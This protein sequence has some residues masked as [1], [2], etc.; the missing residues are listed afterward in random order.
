M[1][2]VRSQHTRY[3]AA[4]GARIPRGKV[5][6]GPGGYDARAS[7]ARLRRARRAA[8]GGGVE[9]LG[10]SRNDPRPPKFSRPQVSAKGG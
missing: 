5:H 1:S 3:C 8:G 4:C 9:S 10:P 7:V 6:R 2:L